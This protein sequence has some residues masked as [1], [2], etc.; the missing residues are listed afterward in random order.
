MDYKRQMIKVVATRQ[1][2]DDEYLARIANEGAM[3]LQKAFAAVQCSSFQKD[4]LPNCQNCRLYARSN[5]EDF[6]N[7]G[8]KFPEN[9]EVRLAINQLFTIRNLIVTGKP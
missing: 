3:E 4:G 1:E 6:E 2:N 8:K 9:C 5:V 7:L